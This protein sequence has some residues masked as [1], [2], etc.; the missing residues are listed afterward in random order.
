MG[1]L[2]FSI[3]NLARK[4][5]IEPESALRKA[6]EK[7][8]ARFER[9][10]R[11]FEA[12]GRSIHERDA[13]RDGSGVD[14]GQVHRD[15]SG[16]T[17]TTA[18]T[19]VALHGPTANAKKRR[20]EEAK[21]KKQTDTLPQTSRSGAGRRPA[22]EVMRDSQ[23]QATL[24]PSWFVFTSHALLRPRFARPDRRCGRTIRCMPS[25]SNG[26]LKFISNPIGS[27]VVRRYDCT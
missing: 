23:K 17:T 22:T 27:A 20:S 4:L 8:S 3:A 13:G 6:N 14:S 12:R 24:D 19:P 21:E 25:F 5:G 1:D 10:E 26:A 7:F 15:W 18:T 11:A 2:L 9:L 16:T